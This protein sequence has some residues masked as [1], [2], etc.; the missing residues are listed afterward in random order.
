MFQE[1]L[2]PDPHSMWQW[3]QGEKKEA[4][5]DLISSGVLLSNHISVIRDQLL[6]LEFQTH[7]IYKWIEPKICLEGVTGAETLPPSGEREP[8]PP[9]NP[10]FYN[11]DTATCS[12][13]PA[14]TYSD[15]M[16]RTENSVDFCPIM[17]A[18]FLCGFLIVFHCV[19]LPA[20][21]QCPAGTEPTLGYEY[22]WW[23]VLPANMKTSCF[24]VGNSKCDSM[25]GGC[26][27]NNTAC[28]VVLSLLLGI[29][30]LS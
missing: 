11:N 16:K 13:C 21:K 26:F 18:C 1:G 8:C 22:K 4:L 25:N 2:F 29:L 6:S 23:N 10:G 3:R 28:L 30:L 17:F 7:V 24:N 5:I 20:C 14:G 27:A 15:G 19:H 9:C 12:P